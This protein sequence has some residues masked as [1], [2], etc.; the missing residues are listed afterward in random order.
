MCP[1]GSITQT[2]IR[3][4]INP[5]SKPIAIESNQVTNN[6][7]VTQQP[8]TY[9]TFTFK[10]RNNHMALEEWQLLSV[11]RL[12]GNGSNCCHLFTNNKHPLLLGK[13]QTTNGIGINV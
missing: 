8:D 7:A 10:H 3:T 6:Y 13:G 1:E 2:T 4:I 12:Q 11:L 9:T 5:S